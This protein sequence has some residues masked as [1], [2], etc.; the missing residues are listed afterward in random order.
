MHNCNESNV[1]NLELRGFH[2]RA[3]TKKGCPWTGIRAARLALKPLDTVVSDS[4][5]DR[6][7]RQQLSQSAM[8]AMWR[9]LCC[10]AWSREISARGCYPFDRRW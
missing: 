1:A 9:L 6:W 10:S 4:I 3:R 2:R 7:H 5:V 8:R